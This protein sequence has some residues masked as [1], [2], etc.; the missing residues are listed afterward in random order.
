[1]I[2]RSEWF[3]FTKGIAIC[4]IVFHHIISG[5]KATYNHW[6]MDFYRI[7]E[8]M[9]MPTFFFISGVLM[10]NSAKRSTFK[11]FV[12]KKSFYFLYLY[13]IW[14]T[15]DV[16]GR[17]TL[18]QFANNKVEFSNVLD[19][20]WEPSF[21][22]WFLYGLFWISLIAYVFR[23]LDGISSLIFITVLC[24]LIK[25]NFDA[26]LPFFVRHSISYLP[27]FMIGFL[28][29]VSWKAWIPKMNSTIP[30]IFS[31]IIISASL[32]WGLL[33]RTNVAIYYLFGILSAL[34]LL[35]ISLLVHGTAFLRLFSYLGK[36][37]LFIFLLHSIPAAALR[38]FL[39]KLIDNNELIAVLTTIGAILI[40]LTV[41]KFTKKT[42]YVEYL[43]KYKW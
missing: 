24:I 11:I 30:I 20:F 36:N 14:N 23:N 19:V 13:I 10:F 32:L 15:L 9:G 35:K 34:F 38:F 41:Y 3:D 16:I 33:D 2:K 5:S 17:S 22:M 28:F 42:P 31:F 18:S 6:F 39:E 12:Q 8:P 1:M 29:S 7:I 40:C 25:Q 37:S 21:S 4:L 26:D 27:F 43:Y